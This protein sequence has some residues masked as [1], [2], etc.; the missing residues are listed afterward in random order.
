MR[1]VH[2][3]ALPPDQ[4]PAVRHSP[5]N[6]LAGVLLVVIWR[7]RS[8]ARI[9]RPVP[10]VIDPVRVVAGDNRAVEQL[11]AAGMSTI[12]GPAVPREKDRLVEGPRLAVVQ[13]ANDLRAVVEFNRAVALPPP[14]VR[15]LVRCS[16]GI[17]R[18]IR[19]C[20]DRSNG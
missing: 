3:C 1:C 11:D 14:T 8:P 20:R 19:S 15:W 2:V 13:A 18:S 16:S 12:S 9:D 10:G 17:P 5:A 4:R 7:R 6:D